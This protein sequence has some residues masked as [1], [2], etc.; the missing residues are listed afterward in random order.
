MSQQSPSSSNDS[1]YQGY[2]TISVPNTPQVPLS[3][4][5]TQ[6]QPQQNPNIPELNLPEIN[7]ETP[8]TQKIQ[9]KIWGAVGAP[10]SNRAANIGQS[11]YG[12]GSTLAQGVQSV[13][14]GI[15][16]GISAVGSG[17]GSV[18][19]Y[20]SPSDE[21][22]LEA[23][24]T[25]PCLEKTIEVLKEIVRQL[26]SNSQYTGSDHLGVDGNIYG[27]NTDLEKLSFCYETALKGDALVEA[28]QASKRNETLTPEDDVLANLNSKSLITN[29]YI[30]RRLD[31]NNKEYNA[32]FLIHLTTTLPTLVAALR[33]NIPFR[34]AHKDHLIGYIT[35]NINKLDVLRS[36]LAIRIGKEY[37]FYKKAALYLGGAAISAAV[38]MKYFKS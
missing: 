8:L 36:V 23:A 14:G 9:R 31:E 29:A 3:G 27:T 20:L 35:N 22:L 17:L 24:L 34:S 5:G 37:G 18:Q 13:A 33:S 19:E 38:W 21:G 2:P 32:N 26:A 15:G 10:I 11:I 1:Q 12:A 30:R 16:T 25:L 7:F 6:Q 4:T 28:S